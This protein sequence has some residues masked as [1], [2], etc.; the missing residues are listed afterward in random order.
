M[1]I[2]Q[3]ETETEKER[4]GTERKVD[5]KPKKQRKHLNFNPGLGNWSGVTSLFSAYDFPYAHR[6]QGILEK[7]Y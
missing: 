2:F 1:V 6:V 5:Q 4:M 3:M 7:K